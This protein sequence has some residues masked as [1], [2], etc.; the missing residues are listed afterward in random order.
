M[1][2]Q[3]D[4]IKPDRLE[5]I[6]EPDS[7]PSNSTVDFFPMFFPVIL[8]NMETHRMSTPDFA[9]PWFTLW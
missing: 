7:R 9:K 4:F 3:C 1:G 8:P 2:I 6:P 5:F